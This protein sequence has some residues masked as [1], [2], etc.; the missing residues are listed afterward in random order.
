MICVLLVLA[1]QASAR[2]SVVLEWN[3]VAL[4]TIQ[5]TSTPPPLAARAL[6]MVH[7]A[8]HDAVNSVQPTHDPFR[9]YVPDSI[10][11][12]RE[13]AAVEAAFTVLWHLYPAER[14]RL[15]TARNGS[16]ERVAQSPGKESGLRLGRLV[17]ERI[18]AWRSSDGAD[19]SVA[20]APREESGWWRPTPPRYEPALMPHWG[21]VAPFA[22]P[23][24]ADFRAP[25]PPKLD[26]AAYARNF[27]EV[28][29]LG[30]ADS[31]RRT[32]DQTEI[33]HFW[34]D[35]AG[36]V[37][38]PGHWNR[39]A[40]TAARSFDLSIEQQAR[41]FALLNVALADAGIVCWETKFACD[42]WR[43][44]TAIHEAASD[45]NG[46]T[47]ADRKWQPLLETPPFP[48]CSSGH[49]TF[50]GAAAQVL[51]LF[52]GRDDI[53][54]QDISGGKQRRFTSFSEAAE[55][56][57]RSR[58]YGGIHFQFDNE[59]GLKSGRAVG[60]YV[61]EHSLRPLGGATASGIASAG[62]STTYFRGPPGATYQNSIQ[63]GATSDAGSYFPYELPIVTALSPLPIDSTPT[64]IVEGSPVAPI[65][66]EPVVME[67]PPLESIPVPL[68]SDYLE[69]GW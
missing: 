64:Y 7:V 39:I 41:L 15:E 23:K 69:F 46:K 35:G 11:T 8:V 12:D 36:T 22:I 34:A 66:A 53:P 26:S 19:G 57:G 30:S 21:A 1:G 51:A 62:T 4:E 47:K 32:A 3:D 6:A 48:S 24:A 37:T 55:E 14:R 31:D 49:S 56:A 43:P 10:D 29:T 61:F 25:S 44:V 9:I 45:N 20:Y 59:G 67:Y 42:F 28:K 17:A 2:P 63:A 50:S 40:Q 54:F 52:F 68:T 27:E 38:P 60:R 65:Y 5:R 33:A 13:A 16:V 58:I 18:I